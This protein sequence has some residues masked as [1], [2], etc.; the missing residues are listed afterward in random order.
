MKVIGF[1]LGLVGI[2]FFVLGM[3]SEP[4]IFFPM[5]IFCLWVSSKLIGTQ[6]SNQKKCPY[7]AE[8]IKNEAIVCRFCGRDIEIEPSSEEIVEQTEANALLPSWKCHCGRINSQAH[9]EC[10]A[11]FF[12]D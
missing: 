12:V 7:C 3:I 11:S 1:F 9:C 6:G 2:F 5:S 10:G 4:L 8:F